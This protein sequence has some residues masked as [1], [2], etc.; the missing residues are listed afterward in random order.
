MA[1][2]LF[3]LCLGFVLSAAIGCGDSGKSAG[4]SGKPQT[5]DEMKANLKPAPKR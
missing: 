4:E 5:A 3:T 1:A 2:L